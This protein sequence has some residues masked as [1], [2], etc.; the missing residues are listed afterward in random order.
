MSMV[1]V[2]M[3]NQSEHKKHREVLTCKREGS[4]CFCYDLCFSFLRHVFYSVVLQCSARLNS[5]LT[6]LSKA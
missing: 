2:G 6:L 1:G 4:K 3:R 5:K